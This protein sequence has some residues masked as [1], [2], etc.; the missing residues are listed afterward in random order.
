MANSKVIK[1]RGGTTAEHNEF[2]GAARELTVDTDKNTVVVHDGATIGGTPLA[3]GSIQESL[4]SLSG[5]TANAL[6]LGVFTGATISDNRTIKQAL[7]ELETGV[8]S[9][10]SSSLST[11]NFNNILS[12]T[13]NTVQKALDVLDN[14]PKISTGDKAKLDLLSVTHA[15]S[16][17]I[18]ESTQGHIVNLTGVTAGNDNLGSFATGNIGP[19]KTIKEA[20]QDIDTRLDSLG[21]S[22]TYSGAFD[23]RSGAFPGGGTAKTGAYYIVSVAGTV[24]GVEFEIG[25]SIIAKVDN[26]ATAT[27]AAN[28][29]KID[30]TDAVTTVAGR[31]G[32][33]VLGQSDIAGLDGKITNVDNLVTLSGVASDSANLGTF[34]GSTIT[35]NAT[36]KTAIQELET[37]V[38]SSSSSFVGLTDTPAA[39]ASGDEGK[40]V[41]VNAAENAV[42]FTSTIDLGLI[43]N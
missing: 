43:T 14:Q 31:V 11:A 8:E 2:T 29:D 28:W 36:V 33:I 35:D 22:M 1:F 18:V 4:V 19:N 34:T 3:I 5:A 24:D 30:N 21:S 10:V 38:E 17:D 7:Q 39:Y 41:V 16:L 32:A 15:V 27:Y 40:F 6:N 12:P 37:K 20:L 13:E 9:I 42:E 23:A 26:A 25:D